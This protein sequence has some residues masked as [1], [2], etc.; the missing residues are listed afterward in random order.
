MTDA[1]LASALAAGAGRLLALV[2][3]EA[4]VGGRELGATGDAVAHEWICRVLRHQRPDDG[5]LSEG[6]DT[7]AP[8]RLSCERV[9]IIDPVDGT[10]DSGKAV[11]IGPSTSRSPSTVHRR[12]PPS[13]YQAW[14]G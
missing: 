11:L 14:I 2:R 10:R 12:P 7:A 13:H 6:G 5:L 1:H 9:W 8:D 4:L 3:A